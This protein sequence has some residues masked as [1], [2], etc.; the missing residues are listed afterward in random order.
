MN[1]ENNLI[2]FNR[3]KVQVTDHIRNTAPKECWFLGLVYGNLFSE[4]E[5]LHHQNLLIIKTNLE[6]LGS[7]YESL[8]N[9]PNIRED[10]T[11]KPGFLYSDG[12]VFLY[13][14]E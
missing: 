3:I 2:A 8:L 10:N 12:A 9:I 4:I 14:R 13:T 6:M 11:L 1:K 5:N 7:H